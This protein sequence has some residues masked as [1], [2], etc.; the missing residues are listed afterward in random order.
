MRRYAGK[1]DHVITFKPAGDSQTEL[2]VT[3]HGYPS[4]QIVEIS[5][6][7]MEQCLDKMAASLGEA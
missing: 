1:E 7:G 5:R 6:S 3:E 4:A 2:T